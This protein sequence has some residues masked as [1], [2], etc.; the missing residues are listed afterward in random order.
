M[1]P[2]NPRTLVLAI[3]MV[4]L[5][6]S[7]AKGQA[8]IVAGTNGSITNITLSNVESIVFKNNNLVVHDTDCGDEYFSI[9]Y[10]DYLTLDGTIDVSDVATSKDAL[11]IYPNPATDYVRVK[12]NSEGSA[13][14]VIYDAIGQVVMTKQVSQQMNTMDVSTLPSGLYLFSLNN[15]TSTF[16][17][18]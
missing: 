2:N 5:S 8:L 12:C 3:A 4:V 14:L 6:F 7:L 13:Q 11:T 10:T 9:F 1:K 16:I 18:P 17:K 15:Q